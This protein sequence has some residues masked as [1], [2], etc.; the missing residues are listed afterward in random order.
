MSSPEFSIVRI[1]VKQGDFNGYLD[2]KVSVRGTGGLVE[3]IG[4]YSIGRHPFSN[5]VGFSS[6]MNARNIL[7]YSMTL[8][9]QETGESSLVKVDQEGLKKL[10]QIAYFIN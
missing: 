8:I 5:V 10:I 3:A 4:L 1:G 6:A 7:I 2:Y 9:C